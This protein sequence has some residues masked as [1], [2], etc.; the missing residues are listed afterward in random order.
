MIVSLIG[1]DPTVSELSALELFFSAVIAG[2]AVYIR[3]ERHTPVGRYL[4]LM[5][6]GA[7]GYTFSSGAHVFITH[8]TVAHIIHNGTYA[9]GALLTAAGTLMIISF[10]NRDGLQHRW[11]VW[12]LLGLVLVD[13]LA[14]VTDPWVGAIIREPIFIEGGAMVRTAEHTGTY[15]SIRNSVLYVLALISLL[16]VII[17]MSDAE[18]IYQQQ[19]LL[20]ATGQAFLITMFLVQLIVPNVPGFDLAS[21]GLFGGTLI[22]V[23]A[24]RRWKFGKLLPIAHK[25]LMDSMDDAVIV[26]SPDN[27]IVN[28][29][30]AASELFGLQ[31]SVVGEPLL[32]CLPVE[33][34]EA[35]PF[36]TEGSGEVRFERHQTQRVYSYQVSPATVQAMQRGRAIIFRDVTVQKEQE[37]MLREARDR[38]QSE[39]DVKELVTRLLLMSSTRHTVAETACQL[40]VETYNCDG[41]SVMWT[42][43]GQELTSVSRGDLSQV[44]TDVIEPLAARVIESGE[45]ETVELNDD[46]TAAT[47]SQDRRITSVQA[48]PI[49]HE[50]LTTGALCVTSAGRPSELATQMTQQI[51]TA[52]GF[53]RTVD[54]QRAALIADNVEEITV[55]IDA[56]HFLSEITADRSLSVDIVETYQT[57]DD[58]VYMMQAESG[59]EDLKTSLRNHD[60]V[61]AVTEASAA[62]V[63]LSVRVQGI[64]VS[65]VLAEFGGITRSIKA[66]AG[67]VTVTAEFA[68]GTDVRAALNAV[69]DEWATARMTK[70]Q[71]QPTALDTHSPADSLTPRQTD[72]LRA[73]TRLGFFERPQR[74]RAEDVAEALGVSRSTALQHIRRGELKIF[75]ELFLEKP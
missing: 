60:R 9:F 61:A 17:E 43:S 48:T 31:Q 55:Q 63:V 22:I 33:A 45:P 29:N 13:T 68:P 40:L 58:I 39:R 75:E 30:P 11:I 42:G 5:L 24:V 18:G 62:P 12:L 73:A 20:I 67:S 72:V 3:H 51:A 15:F 38:A 4:L 25:T 74:A 50:Q 54:D 70:R 66:E 36:I 59:I 64:T 69:S 46:D 2:T 16:L 7:C 44:E 23:V 41:A 27:R 65:T 19:L 49:K 21:V 37:D 35:A 57:G 10:T 6:I 34:A 26:L 47:V 32:E 56:N 52:L 71:Q 8:P 14:A 53:K 28:I 1:F